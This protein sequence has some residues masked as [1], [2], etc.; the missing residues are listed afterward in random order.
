MANVTWD[1]G[2]QTN[3]TL[4]GA[5]LIATTGTGGGAVRATSGQANGKYYFEITINTLGAL[6]SIGLLPNYLI[7]ALTTN[8]FLSTAYAGLRVGNNETSIN[9]FLTG[10]SLGTA[11]NGTVV[12]FAVDYDNQRLWTRYG[13]AGNWNGS[14]TANPTTPSTG[15][16]FTGLG[17]VGISLLPFVSFSGTGGQVTANFGDSTFTGTVPTGFTSGMPTGGAN[18]ALI[19][20][21]G[22]EVWATNPSQAR[23]TQIGSEVW[24]NPMSPLRVSQV[25]AEVWSVNTPALRVSQVGVEAW[26]SVAIGAMPAAGAVTITGFVPIP[27][28]SLTAQPASGAISFTGFAPTSVNNAVV[29]PAAGAI[30]FTGFAPTPIANAVASPASGAITFTGFIPRED[31]DSEPGAGAIII[32]GF[33]PTPIALAASAPMFSIIV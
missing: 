29:T 26:V 4:T 1:S 22:S 23:F 5:S 28:A 20:Q 11:A 21:I 14:G 18:N 13:A 2:F 19:T 12:C 8:G 31:E 33:A 32:T 27:V 17:S 15:G 3:I 7:N 24:V 30:I 6:F 9:G 25:G 10:A 16:S